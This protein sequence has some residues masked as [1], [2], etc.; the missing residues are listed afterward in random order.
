MEIQYSESDSYSIHEVQTWGLEL[1]FDVLFPNI[2]RSHGLSSN[3]LLS[4]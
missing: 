2:V 3:N 4:S 1:L